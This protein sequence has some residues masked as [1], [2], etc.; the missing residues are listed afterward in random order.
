MSN[1]YLFDVDG[2]LTPSRDK[3]DPLFK[4]AFYE[5][6]R[7]KE[8]YIVSGGSFPRLINQLGMD[9]IERMSGVFPCM[10]NAFYQKRD[11]ISANGYS[12]WN[13]IYENKFVCP[14][15]LKRSL[16]SIVTK[17]D[18]STKTGKH[19]E[20]RTG[21]INF[22]VVGRNANTVER[23]CYEEWDAENHERREIVRKLRKK[24][25]QLD[26]VIGGAVSID[27]FNEG[28]DKSQI[29]KRY[30]KE[31]LEHNQ[32]H[33]VGDRISFPGNDCSLAEVLRAHKNG[34][35]YEVKRWQDTA[36]LLKTDAFV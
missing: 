28:N 13:I 23:R 33:F 31:A 14:R 6:G 18:F 9:I 21:M 24:Y 1:I 25:P 12:E 32:I 34:R 2:T 15:N 5:W 3:I 29:L 27:I 7:D 22:S 19:Y 16:N 30:F 4:K 11:Q 8:V 35:P 20:E 10:G 26:F 36:E 17:S